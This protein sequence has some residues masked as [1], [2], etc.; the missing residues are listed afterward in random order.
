MPTEKKI[1]ILK[2]NA[3]KYYDEIER[4]KSQD[5]KNIARLNKD[6]EKQ[7]SSEKF[8]DAI[9]QLV[10]DIKFKLDDYTHDEGIMIYDYSHRLD[11]L[12]NMSNFVECIVTNKFA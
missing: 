9:H 5:S 6:Y 7:M 12:L 2:K 8:D 3:R 10:L 1:N 11:S 4:L